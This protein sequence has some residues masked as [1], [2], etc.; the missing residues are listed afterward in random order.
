MIKV[1]RQ[2]DFRKSGIKILRADRQITLSILQKEQKSDD[3]K[4]LSV[5]FHNIFKGFCICVRLIQLF[6]S[7]F[8]TGS[9]FVFF[10]KQ[11]VSLILLID[12]IVC[13]IIQCMP[14]NLQVRLLMFLQQRM[15]LP[16]N[17]ILVS[18][19]VRS[20]CIEPQRRSVQAFAWINAIKS[21]LAKYKGTD[22]VTQK[23]YVQ[24]I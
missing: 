24:F 23:V 1:R 10:G 6:Q 18:L 20:G 17:L 3:V 12:K 22:I 13:G 7:L 15:I 9:A 5:H 16:I 2:S 4:S 11:A 14:N 21:N 8:K 19:R